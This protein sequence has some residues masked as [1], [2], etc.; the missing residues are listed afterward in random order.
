MFGLF[1]KKSGNDRTYGNKSILQ[2]SLENAEPL[3]DEE[4]DSF[5][6]NTNEYYFRPVS[7]KINIVVWIAS[8]KHLDFSKY[9]VKNLYRCHE[10]F[11]QYS[12]SEYL[13]IKSSFLP[14]GKIIEKKV[15]DNLFDKIN[16]ESETYKVSYHTD[17]IPIYCSRRR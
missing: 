3:T 12:D 10:V 5:N 15:L 13:V 14:S 2:R 9:S 17:I 7:E 11:I 1:S 6:K 16:N 8:P 4:W